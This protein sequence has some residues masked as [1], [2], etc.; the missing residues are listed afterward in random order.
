MPLTING[1]TVDVPDPPTLERLLR[2]MASRRPF[3]VALNEEFIPRDDYAWC[4][5]KD[6]DRIEIVHPAAGG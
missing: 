3:A 4:E 2:D 6:G 1:A 5:L